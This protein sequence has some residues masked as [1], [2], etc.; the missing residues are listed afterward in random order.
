MHDI[1]E[2]ILSFYLYHRKISKRLDFRDNRAD[3]LINGS[4]Y[5]V[6]V[7]S[8]DH[9]LVPFNIFELFMSAKNTV[10]VPRKRA[11][12]IFC[13]SSRLLNYAEL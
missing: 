10:S 1:H 12:T 11:P 6:L 3:S 13:D 8:D 7:I 9:E 5:K 4:L 2:I